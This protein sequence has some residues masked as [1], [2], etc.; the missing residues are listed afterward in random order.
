MSYWTH[1]IGVINVNPCG[2]TQH[3]MTYIVNTV[4]DHLPVV[5][6]SEG[7][8]EVF[9]N[10]NPH[11][12]R[13]SSCDE[14]GMRTNN[15]KDR[16]GDRSIRTGWLDTSDDYYLT[17]YG[18]FRDRMFKQTF[19][20]FQKWIC[21]LAKRLEV[22]QGNITITSDDHK[23][24]HLILESW[25]NPYIDMFE[26]PTWGRTEEEPA[27]YEYLMWKPDPYSGLPME[28][29]YKYIDSDDIDMEME[30]RATWG[31]MRSEKLE[32][33]YEN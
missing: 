18:D 8:M 10:F 7:D 31:K 24:Y 27:W 29:M 6:G 12:N 5:S 14:F 9:V 30:R 21:R 1:I 11:H 13:S 2:R 25:K 16:Y 20:E 19:H 23:P 33:Y 22:I 3:E 32:K 26:Y 4:L 17:I 28:H 15:L